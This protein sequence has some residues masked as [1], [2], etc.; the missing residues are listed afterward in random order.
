MDPAVPADDAAPQRERRAPRPRLYTR[1]ELLGR[2]PLR[3]RRRSDR[4]RLAVHAGAALGMAGLSAWWTLP[5]HWFAG[6]VLVVVAPGRGI[7]L[8]D[9][10]ALA[11]VG[12]AL[13]SLLIVGR[14]ARTSTS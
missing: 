8:G 13:R 9:L 12:V 10:P 11:F 6:P 7:H 4:V 3:F 5:L 2:T 1:D 14:I